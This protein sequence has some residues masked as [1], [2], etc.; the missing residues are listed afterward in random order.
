[1]KRAFRDKTFYS[2]TNRMSVKTHETSTTYIN[3][4]ATRTHVAFW[5]KHI[6]NFDFLPL[7]AL[8]I[9]HSGNASFPEVAYK[10]SNAPVKPPA[11][12]VDRI[13]PETVPPKF[14]KSFPFIE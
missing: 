3:Q 1:M 4:K 9:H 7:N 10:P 5:S 13:S 2:S 12:F 6:F 8:A 14:T 11:T